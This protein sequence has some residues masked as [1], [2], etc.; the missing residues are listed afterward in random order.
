MHI[1]VLGKYVY[2]VCLPETHQIS[3]QVTK[4]SAL[5]GLSEPAVLG[6]SIRRKVTET[7]VQ[8]SPIIVCARAQD[9]T[10]FYHRYP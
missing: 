2:M 10:A 7:S 5:L 6:H 3:L 9:S 1:H 4:S 8:I